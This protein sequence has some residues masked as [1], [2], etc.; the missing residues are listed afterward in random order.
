MGMTTSFVRKNGIVH[1]GLQKT[2]LQIPQSSTYS[3]EVR[4]QDLPFGW[5]L[6]D[7]PLTPKIAKPLLPLTASVSA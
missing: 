2:Q 6:Q 3:I 4:L 5:T 7:L 1:G